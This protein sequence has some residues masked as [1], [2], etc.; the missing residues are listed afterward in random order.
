MAVMKHIHQAVS[1]GRPGYPSPAPRVLLAGPSVGDLA[2]AVRRLKPEAEV[3]VVDTTLDALAEVALA[4]DA[5]PFEAVFADVREASE[6]QALRDRLDA[7]GLPAGRLVITSDAVDDWTGHGADK[8]IDLPVRDDA[9]LHALFPREAAEPIARPGRVGVPELDAETLLRVMT[10][11]LGTA[12]PAAVAA[13]NGRSSTPQLT[14]ADKA[15]PAGSLSVKLSTGQTL[16]WLGGAQDEAETDVLRH[17]L[18]SLADALSQLVAIDRKYAKLKRLAL[19]DD[20]TGCA[21]KKYFNHFL[22]GILERARRDRFPVTLLVFDIDNFKNYNDRHGHATGDR[23]LKETGLL[24]RRCVRDH[25]FV[26]RI[27]GD[28]FAVIFCETDD[29]DTP[30]GVQDLRRIG[31]VPKGPLQIAARFR[32]L[33]SSPEFAALGSTGVG[34]LTISGGMSVFPYDA[35][36]AEGL[37]AKADHALVFGAKRGGKDGISLVGDEPGDDPIA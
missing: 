21:N 7:G 30:E 32:R 36:D 9:L 4:A 29:G 1:K 19:F 26:G 18:S 17:E 27:G 25:D 37:L 11:H 8:A 33:I 24:I 31:R 23:I 34:R 14:L 22:G 3:E 16:T 35:T 5:Q 10:T 12:V 28:E 6:V 20:L 15:D 2:D 13:L